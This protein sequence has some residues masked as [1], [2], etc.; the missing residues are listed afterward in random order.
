MK[1]LLEMEK[2]GEITKKEIRDILYRRGYTM[3]V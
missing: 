3:K 2:R 1:E